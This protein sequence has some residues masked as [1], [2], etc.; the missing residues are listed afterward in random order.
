MGEE[1]VKFPGIKRYI[2]LEWPLAVSPIIQLVEKWNDDVIGAES[3][4]PLLKS[5]ICIPRL[6]NSTGQWHRCQQYRF[7]A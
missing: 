6:P 3:R 4:E 1:G 5:T 2:T 7:R